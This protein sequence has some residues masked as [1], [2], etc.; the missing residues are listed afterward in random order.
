[1]QA[2]AGAVRGCVG[3]EEEE[4]EEE[5]RTKGKRL[6]GKK[7]EVGGRVVGGSYVLFDGNRVPSVG[8]PEEVEGKVDWV[9]KGDGKVRCIA[10]ASILAKVTRDRIMLA[11]HEDYPQYN[12]AQHKG[13]PT[14]AHKAALIKY[15]P[16]PIHRM[17]FA[18]IKK[19]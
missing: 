12:F 1:M 18:P 2:M 6:G 4:E 13:Y 16:C 10:A 3:R 5:G 11:Y 15:G 14:P 19:K 17:T 9:V 7:E 8:L